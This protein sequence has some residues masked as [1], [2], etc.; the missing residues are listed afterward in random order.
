MRKKYAKI[1]QEWMSERKQER[2]SCCFV[3]FFC[4]LG[5]FR[6]FDLKIYFLLK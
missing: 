1:N 2:I 5:Y 3:L 6:Q 4:A